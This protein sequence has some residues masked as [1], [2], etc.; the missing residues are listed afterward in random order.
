MRC[1]MNKLG[2]Y[3]GT[4][5]IGYWSGF[6][7]SHVGETSK[8]VVYTWDFPVV[9][10]IFMLITFSLGYFAGGGAWNELR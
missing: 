9:I 8:L 6:T 5:W 2:L 1:E 7:T 3:G 10:A 4:A